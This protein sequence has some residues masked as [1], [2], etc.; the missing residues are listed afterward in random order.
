VVHHLPRSRWAIEPPVPVIAGLA[1]RLAV[2]ACEGSDGIVTEPR[3]FRRS[4]IMR[5]SRTAPDRMSR[6]PLQRLLLTTLLSVIALAAAA[7]FGGRVALER[8]VMPMSGERALA[9]LESEVEVLFDA[10]GIPRIRAETDADALRTLGWLHAGERL[11]QMELLRAVARGELAA[12][13]GPAGLDSDVLHRRYGFAR[14]I[15]QQPPGLT[16]EIETLLEA[17]VGGI[18]ARIADDELPP[19]F[20]LLGRTPRPWTVADVLTLAYY[21]TW[22]PTTLVRRLERAWRAAAEAHGT[23]ATEWL[24]DLPAWGV[25]SV[26]AQ[27]MTEASNTW[28]VAPEKSASGHALHASDPHLDYTMA[29]GLWY[30]AG[31]H[32]DETLDVVGVTAPGLPFVAMGHN[33]RIAFAFTVA[34]VAL[35]DI[36]RFARDP[37]DPGR[38]VGP[39]RSF[40]IVERRE[41]FEIR[42]RDEPVTRTIATTRFGIVVAE[43]EEHV[44]ILRWAGFELP[45]AKLISNGLAINRASDFAK[46][47]TA[48]SD[49]GAL[50]VNWSYSDRDGN[51]GYVQSTP[52]PLRRHSSFYVTL[53]GDRPIHHWAGFVPP[54]RR[55]AT[56]NPDQGWLAN[57]NNHAAADAPYPMP[58]FY[59]HMRMRRAAA[60]LGNGEEF[61]AAD[62]R[63]LQLDR[64]SDRALAWKGW[65]ADT[66]EATGRGRLG[67]EI[68]TWDGVM[69]AESD[70]A[71]LFSLWWQALAGQLFADS[72][73]ETWRQGRTLLDDWLHRPPE[74]FELTAAA[75]DAAAR[76]ALDE[77]LKHGIRPLG[78]IQTLT[79][80]HPLSEAGFLDAWLSLS[81]GPFPIGGD[82]GS[83]NV[84]YHRFDA[85]NKRLHAAA[86]ASMRF[87][88]DWADP[89]AFTLNLTLGQ[90][91]HP[92]SPHF[93]DFLPAFRDGEPWPVPF[94]REAVERQT[95]S[96]L[97]LR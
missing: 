87:V 83:L 24:A 57:A 37:D 29:P 59:K 92:L 80:A 45:I 66:A 38:L 20:R 58:G 60:A 96:R 91:G 71:G 47:R 67:D 14:R 1:A 8:S 85:V 36:Y 75:R 95:A 50:S 7:W 23:A 28:V 65:L 79:I 15:E 46:F 70:I 51:I 6:F 69:R 94:S 4:G 11:F 12:I 30:A 78:A 26:P 31:I 42:G 19:S 40:P 62:M 41:T 88:M 82:P 34:P 81:R 35:D 77:A 63:A 27:R 44:D 84:T 56:L 5:A 43:T 54:E 25:P 17:Y 97:L 52:V 90:S 13:V 22:Y 21:Q 39:G 49:M 86:G 33:G 68:R 48:A 3:G 76:R 18:N 32:S 89:D 9:G 2:E 53:A 74:G 72:G 93:D 10:R 61:T 73:L 55:P 16:A 64:T